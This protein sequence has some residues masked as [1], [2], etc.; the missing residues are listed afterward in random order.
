MVMARRTKAA[1]R[2]QGMKER[3]QAGAGRCR[4]KG[5]GGDCLTPLATI[6]HPV[7]TPSSPTHT[8]SLPSHTP[9][10]HTLTHCLSHSRPTCHFQVHTPRHGA[11]GIVHIKERLHL[12]PDVVIAP[13]LEAIARL[14]VAVH[15]VTHPGNNLAG[16]V[17]D[18]APDGGNKAQ[19]WRER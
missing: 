10:S 5:S 14:G 9:F 2:K 13:R 11:H 1:A 17:R 7:K 19:N 8:S 18:M 12:G 3:G 6:L 4:R 15:G 16:R